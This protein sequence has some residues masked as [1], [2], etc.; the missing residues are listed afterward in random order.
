MVSDEMQL[1]RLLALGE[2]VAL[3]KFACC[4]RVLEDRV[5]PPPDGGTFST[6]GFRFSTGGRSK[7]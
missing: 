1:Q 3:V 2:I 7:M 5:Y 6:G 4:S